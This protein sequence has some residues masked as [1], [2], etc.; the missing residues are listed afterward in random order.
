MRTGVARSPRWSF[1]THCH[2]FTQLSW[3]CWGLLHE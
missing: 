3:R 1:A 2:H